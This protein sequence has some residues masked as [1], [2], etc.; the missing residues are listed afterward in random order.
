MSVTVINIIVVEN[1]E[2]KDLESFPV[3]EEQLSDDVVEQAENHMK[4]K[5][6]EYGADPNDEETL[7]SYVEDG[8]YA[9]SDFSITLMWTTI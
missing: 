1:N 6:I 7:E 3:W 9:G 5:M 8:V 2:V 4:K